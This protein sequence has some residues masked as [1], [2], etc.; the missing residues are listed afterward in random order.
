MDGRRTFDRCIFSP[1]DIRAGRDAFLEASKKP[2]KA[3]VE[4]ALTLNTETDRWSFDDEHEFFAA[5]EQGFLFAEYE[6]AWRH[7]IVTRHTFKI[8]AARQRIDVHTDVSMGESSRG[9]IERVL[10]VFREAADRAR[11]PHPP[12]PPKP[13]PIVF[14]GHGGSGQWRDLKDHLQDQHGYKVVAYETGARAG[15]TIRD[16]LDSMMSEAT[17]AVL[18][19]TAEDLQADGETMRARQN[20]VHEVGLFQGALGWDRAIVAVEKGAEVFSNLQGIH[21]L[22]YSE[23]NIKEIFGD[24]LATLKREFPSQ[25]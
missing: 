22:R 1:R 25:L 17:F 7:N 16:V 20:V 4:F 6:V 15:H 19:M 13:R 8:Y 10:S 21:Q 12:S 14:I 3:E 18:V 2:A 5:Y 23:G 9:E 24:V 11:V